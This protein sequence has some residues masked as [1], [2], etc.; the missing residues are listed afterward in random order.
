MSE[1]LLTV[2]SSPHIRQQQ[3]TRSIMTDVLIALAPASVLSVVFF[4]ILCAR[5]DRDMCR[6][7]YLNR[8]DDAKNTKAT[9][10][11]LRYVGSRNRSLIGVESADPRNMVDGDHR[12]SICNYRSK[13]IIWGIGT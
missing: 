12:L 3:T 9:D 10:N 2:S 13:T 11:D 6:Y 5:S 7:V 4:R 8:V 1:K